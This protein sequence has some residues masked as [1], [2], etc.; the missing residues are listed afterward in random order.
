MLNP[1]VAQQVL[2]FWFGAM[3]YQVQSGLWWGGAENDL[4]IATQ[5]ARTVEQALAGKLSHWSDSADTNLALIVLSDQMTRN[6]YRGTE[7]AFTG[8]EL[9]RESMNKGLERGDLDRYH[10]LQAVFFLMPLEH[11]ESI[12]S[13]RQAVALLTETRDR[14]EPKHR[15]ILQSN[16]D[17]AT[18]H[19]LIIQRF[20]RFPHRNQALGRPSTP[21]EQAYLEAGGRRFGQ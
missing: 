3:P 6:I 13:Q 14:A 1:P 12:Q 21:D 10:P 19:Q 7:L 18:E 5:W 9:A 16:L 20:G 11:H 2:K 8:D 4:C 17:F 15:A